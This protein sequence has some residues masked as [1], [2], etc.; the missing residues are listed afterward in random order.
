MLHSGIHPTVAG[1]LLAF[2]IPF[3]NGNKK[4]A[5]RILQHRLHKPVAF[6]ILP[7][8]ALANTAIVFSTGW[9]SGLFS[10]EGWG[11]L[12]GLVFGKPAGILLFATIAVSTGICSLQ[13]H[14]TWRQLAGAALLAGIGFTMSIFITM[15]A[16]S[17]P[18]HIA[19]AKTAIIFASLIS[20]IAGLLWL[21]FTL[22]ESIKDS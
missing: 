20:A 22:P 1:V 13:P 9:S 14:L 2:S 19:I 10:N 8:F 15:L 18:A 5:S 12:S 11:I 3:G 6:F 16:F 17:N 7:V 4:T 21:H